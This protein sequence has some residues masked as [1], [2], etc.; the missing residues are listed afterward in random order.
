[1]NEIL[2][3]QL[4]HKKEN[5]YFAIV[6]VFSLLTYL[7]LTI[8]VVGIVIIVLM[9]LLSLFL[10]ALMLGGIRRVGVRLT[11]EQFPEVYHRANELSEKMGLVKMPDVY[12]LESQ[13]MLNAFATRFFGRNMVVLYSEIFELIEREAEEEL[14]FVMA[15]EF[16]HIKRKHVLVHLLLLPAMWVPFVGNAYVRAC[17]YTCDR[18][19]AYYVGALEPSRNALTLLAIGK[20]LYKK[21]NQE[22]YMR[23]METEA[24]FFAWLH[25]KLST[26]PHLPKRIYEL[27]RFFAAE[28]TP[29]LRE[30]KKKIIVGIVVSILVILLAVGGSYTFYKGLEKLG[31]FSLSD[32][33]EVEGMTPLMDAAN[34]NDVDAIQKLLD[35][36]VDLEEVDVDGTTA[37]HWAVFNMNLEAA[38]LLLENGA[39]PN[40]VDYYDTSPLMSAVFNEDVEMVQLLLENGADKEFVDSAGYTA[41]DYS[42]DYENADIQELVKP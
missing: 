37:L 14:L 9:I 2:P 20:D 29:L 12:I 8:S 39:D 33:L 34:A 38:K 31:L 7:F 5:V 35:E 40:A 15:H 41:Y 21:V 27:Q 22:A 3:S 11:E 26:H 18:H 17:E 1:M 13:G 4:V 23:Q 30:P 32:L 36:G 28:Q 6:L 19:A 16:A 42:L 24:G 25:E 10:H